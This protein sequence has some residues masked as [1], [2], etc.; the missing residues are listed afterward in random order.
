MFAAL[1]LARGVTEV[2]NA[3]PR[4]P[5][6]GSVV[7]LSAEFAA[8]ALGPDADGGV[9]IQLAVARFSAYV[10]ELESSAGLVSFRFPSRMI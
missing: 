8:A 3:S 1:L 5:L 10:R 2:C 9:V 4:A 6:V 7:A